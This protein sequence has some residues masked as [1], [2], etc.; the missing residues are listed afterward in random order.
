MFERSPKQ[1]SEGRNVRPVIATVA[2]KVPQYMD[3]IQ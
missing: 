1:D 2:E 3:V